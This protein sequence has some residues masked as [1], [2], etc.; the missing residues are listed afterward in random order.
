[1]SNK[2]ARL[3]SAF[4]AATMVVTMS[5]MSVFA[6]DADNTEDSGESTSQTGG[7]GSKDKD[8]EDKEQ[9][10]KLYGFDALGEQENIYVDQG[11]AKESIPFPV[12]LNAYKA[13]DSGDPVLVENVTW[14]STTYNAD[15]LGTYDFTAVL[16]ESYELA[17][18][19][20]LPVIHVTVG[21][22]SLITW[23]VETETVGPDYSRS[24]VGS[25]SDFT[26]FE[27]QLTGYSKTFYD[28]ITNQM[29]KL[30]NCERIDVDL[31]GLTATNDSQLQAIANQYSSDLTDAIA[32][33]DREDPTICWLD[34]VAKT[35]FGR[36][37]GQVFAIYQGQFAPGYNRSKVDSVL[38]TMRDKVNTLT[39]QATGGTLEKLRYLHNWLVDNNDYNTIVANGGG[40]SSVGNNEPWEPISAL[41]GRKGS[42]GPV[43]EGYARAFKMLAEDIGVKTIL[44]SGEGDGGAGAG[45]H[46]WNYVKLDGK[47]YAVDVTWDDPIITGTLPDEYRYKHFLVGSDTFNSS[48]HRPSGIYMVSGQSGPFLYPE[49]ATEAYSDVDPNKATPTLT[50][51][52]TPAMEY[53]SEV[54]S[55]KNAVT[56]KA[57]ASGTDVL[58]D[59]AFT[60]PTFKPE[61][62]SYKAGI[63]F[64]PKDTN[65]YNKARGEVT[66]TVNKATVTPAPA[67]QFLEIAQGDTRA[68]TFDLSGLNLPEGQE[69]TYTV[70]S[71]T[72]SALSNASVSGSTLSYTANAGAALNS[73][74][75]FNIVAKT[76]NYNDVTVTFTATIKEE[77][78]TCTLNTYPASVV[79]GN[80][81]E[82]PAGM[83]VTTEFGSGRE[84]EVTP[85]TLAMLSGYD[86]N[87]TGPDSIGKKTITVTPDSNVPARKA[88]FEIN[89]E[90]VITGLTITDGN[91]TLNEKKTYNV[92]DTLDLAGVTVKPVTKS[93]IN[94]QPVAV[95]ADMLN[96]STNL[97]TAGTV[98]FNVTTAGATGLNAF[99]KTNAFYAQV[100]ESVKATDNIVI[101]EGTQL[102]DQTTKQ[103][104]PDADVD[105]VELVKAPLA[106][107]DQA[108]A[109]KQMTSLT[110][111]TTPQD[112]AHAMDISLKLGAVEIQPS[113]AISVK[114][115]LSAIGMDSK[116]T[117][118]VIKHWNGTAWEDINFSISGS[119][120]TMTGITHLSPFVFAWKSYVAPPPTPDNDGGWNVFPGGGG[121]SHSGQSS[122]GSGGKGSSALRVGEREFWNNV[123]TKAKKASDGDTI[124]INARGYD[125]MPATI[126]KSILGRD[127]TL[128]ISWTGG[129]A[130]T[131]YG[132]TAKAPE[133]TRIYY[134]LSLLAEL[135]ADSQPGEIE[136]IGGTVEVKRYDDEGKAIPVTGGVWTVSAPASA[137]LDAL[138]ITPK[139]AGLDGDPGM[140]DVNPAVVQEAPAKVEPIKQET[141]PAAADA[142]AGPAAQAAGTSLPVG[143]AAALAVALALAMAG[144]IAIVRRRNDGQ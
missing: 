8:K 75:T 119:T 40:P 10:T 82:L 85:V 57:D 96:R 72:G 135:Y 55:V 31:P 50:I 23:T 84:S 68:K 90:D 61:A 39:S 11:L 126:I 77:T 98:Y 133:A 131:I 117:N 54:N 2:W 70:D 83:T 4:V 99:T 102:I 37:N 25:I 134:P 48:N 112:Q 45:D 22:P 16:P 101:P 81:I 20:T 38:S 27:D 109:N 91:S 63:L 29:E 51:T 18:G 118:L 5:G 92:G 49:L 34:N 53:G 44:V 100:K 64:T 127:I 13:Q 62:G 111:S 139:D 33:L 26:S 121:G 46:M 136:P 36:R 56:V 138:G 66:I 73:T 43:C 76:K 47:W 108:E 78:Y 94:Q 19:V 58:G 103:P 105:K 120:I 60:D 132:T 30:K 125:K 129:S 142:V 97:T 59:W 113:G 88:T 115:A 107:A 32:I 52:G 106:S 6:A 3:L 71:L 12:T 130:I 86:K 114:I 110:A 15:V 144:G 128:V 124:K 140:F 65:A 9:A 93:Q 89:V 123:L 79:L 35:G 21:E 80:D 14:N 137:G 1:M 7:T 69:W 141:A 95:T 87:A 74:S 42:S 28:G 41:D 24:I 116:D 122:G 67:A 17:E 104:V 143:A